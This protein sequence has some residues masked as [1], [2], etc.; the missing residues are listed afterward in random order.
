MEKKIHGKYVIDVDYKDYHSSYKDPFIIFLKKNQAK[1]NIRALKQRKKITLEFSAYH[2]KKICREVLKYNYIFIDLLKAIDK[3][4]MEDYAPTYFPPKSEYWTPAPSKDVELYEKPTKRTINIG[5]KRRKDF[6]KKFIKKDKIENY[7]PTTVLLNKSNLKRY[8]SHI[9]KVIKVEEKFGQTK[10]L[11][12]KR[13]FSILFSR[14]PVKEKKIIFYLAKRQI[15]KLNNMRK[16]EK[17]SNGIM[18][19]F[20][21]NQLLK[22]YKEVI[23]INSEIYRYLKYMK[24][25]I[26]IIRLFNQN[27]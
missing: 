6:L 17:R 9:K 18:I 3:N 19:N 1:D 24:V 21:N 20:S 15:K 2:F 27:S 26:K 23:R 13:K 11:K 22:T 14:F 25:I 5:F 4:E 10:L 16:N 12:N 8:L 7:H